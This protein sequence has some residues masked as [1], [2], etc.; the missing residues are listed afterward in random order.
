M[1]HLVHIC[2]S[3]LKDLM[4][5]EKNVH[6]VNLY[7]YYDCVVKVNFVFIVKYNVFEVDFRLEMEKAMIAFVSGDQCQNQQFPSLRLSF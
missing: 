4:I 1:P 6:L 3:L 2:V 5:D 7:T